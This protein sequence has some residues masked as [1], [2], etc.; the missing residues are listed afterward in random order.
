MQLRRGMYNAEEKFVDTALR[1]AAV[2]NEAGLKSALFT[3][4]KAAKFLCITSYHCTKTEF[5]HSQRSCKARLVLLSDKA[6]EAVTS[7]ALHWVDR[8]LLIILG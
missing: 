4:L 3:L 8:R 2:S 6:A 5:R 7:I 1:S